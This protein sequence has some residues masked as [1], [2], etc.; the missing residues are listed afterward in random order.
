[1]VFSAG[2]GSSQGLEADISETGKLL[3]A[4]IRWKDF[5]IKAA[6]FIPYFDILCLRKG[7]T[8]R[9][10]CLRE[11]SGTEKHLEGDQSKT[12]LWATYEQLVTYGKKARVK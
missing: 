4:A 2:C 10:F 11:L 8:F 6:Y 1:M 5:D 7:S 12:E 3:S 9:N